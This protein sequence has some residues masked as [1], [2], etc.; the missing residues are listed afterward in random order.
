MKRN[1]YPS[2]SHELGIPIYLDTNSPLDIP[3]SMEGGFS[4]SDSVTT[5]SSN[6]KNTQ[7]SAGVEFGIS[8]LSFF[9]IRFGRA[10]KRIKGD[11]SSQ[12][13][14]SERKYT[15]GSLLN[16]LRTKL[17]EKKIVNTSQRP[18]HLGACVD[19]EVLLL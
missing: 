14:V 1:A 8:F 16:K 3:A 12:E 7:L 17:I 10:G 5:Y 18:G 6:S 2:V 9:P 11:E 13:R 4:M 15:Y 19:S